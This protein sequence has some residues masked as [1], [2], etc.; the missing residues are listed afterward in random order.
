MGRI[1][2]V[3][4]HACLTEYYTAPALHAMLA[5]WFAMLPANL[6]P[7]QAFRPWPWPCQWLHHLWP[8]IY[9]RYITRP[10]NFRFLV[11]KNLCFS[12][13]YDFPYV[14]RFTVPDFCS[15]PHSGSTRCERQMQHLQHKEQNYK[16]VSRA[17][18][19]S[20]HLK[21]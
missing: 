16:Q 12:S 5:S 2:L 18:I 20:I 21:P 17:L 1:I 6:P 14:A 4:N 10:K 19:V 3:L 8:S 9:K 15:A 7:R 11:H 13:W